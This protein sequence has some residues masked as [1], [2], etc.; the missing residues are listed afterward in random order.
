MALILDGTNGLSDIDGSAA[1]PA[2][3]GTDANT[4]IFF[5]AADTIAFSEGGTE[6]A[7]FNSSGNLGVGTASPSARLHAQ[8]ATVSADVLFATNSNNRGLNVNTN[9]SDNLQISHT[10]SNYNIDYWVSGTGI[11]TFSTAGAERMRITS[12]GGLYVACT[13]E[14]SSSVSGWGITRTGA[15]IYVTQGCSTTANFD[16]IYFYTSGGLA[17][18]IRTNGTTTTYNS[19]SDVRLKENIVDAPSAL[20]TVNGIKVRSFDW[21][22]TQSNVKYGFIAQELNEVAPDA[23]SEGI[24]EEDIWAVDTSMLVPMLTKA[25]QEL[26][27]ELDS[28][29]AEL[30]TLKA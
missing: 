17:G 29:K 14:P 4:G 28:V 2:I 3:R 1:T 7:R 12:A 25:I 19:V 30:A 18:N 9:A 24:K 11:H 22:S 15:G 6:S 10:N 26:K 27:S 23:V 8:A 16:H 21:K 20:S 13:A 5:P